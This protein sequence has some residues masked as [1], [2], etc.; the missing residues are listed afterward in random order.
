MDKTLSRVIFLTLTIIC[1]LLPFAAEASELYI[2][3]LQT[4]KDADLG[5]ALVNPTLST[6][7]VTLTARSYAG[8]I[9]AGSQIVNPV[10]LALPASTQKALGITEIFGP[11]I[12]GQSGWVEISTSTSAVKGLFLF[13]NSSLTSV[14]GGELQ[15]TPSSRV[16]FPNVST[17]TSS[18]TRL[19]LVNTAAQD[20]QGTV[21]L[22]ENSGRLA[23]SW[24]ITL[25]GM[26]GFSGV[27]NELVPAESGF[28]GYV[29]VDSTT[30]SGSEIPSLI[31][32]ETYQDRA[33]IA[34]IRAFPESA[35]LR[36]GFLP[37]DRKSV[38]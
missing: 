36:T 13:Y 26:S 34:L 4:S 17:D 24:N 18:Q 27:V 38:V 16:I 1:V 12:S 19:S 6:A 20:M 32:I 14:D 10:T 25:A 30:N 37:Q 33:D 8:A 28:Q 5:L 2:P 35:R 21:S 15:T 23:G 29:V 7:Q 22:Y 11:G 9:I 3:A 31:G